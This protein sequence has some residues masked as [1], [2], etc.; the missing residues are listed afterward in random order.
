MF[1]LFICG[2]SRFCRPNRPELF[3]VFATLMPQPSIGPSSLRRCQ[4]AFRQWRSQALPKQLAVVAAPGRLRALSFLHDAT[5]KSSG[6]FLYRSNPCNL[7]TYIFGCP[8]IFENPSSQLDQLPKNAGVYRFMDSGGALLYIGKAKDLSKRIRAYFEGREHGPHIKKMAQQI[9]RLETISTASELEA[10]LLEQ[11]LIHQHKPKYNIIFRDDKT[12]GYVAITR[13]KHPQI[14]PYRGKRS[15][16]LELF[17]PHV[18]SREI[19]AR[20]EMA[21]KVFK[22]R[23]CDDS[24]YANRSRPC[25][26]HQ[27]GRCSAPC[28]PGHIADADYVAQVELARGYLSGK[29]ASLLSNMA[30]QMEEA[31]AKMEF[32]RAAQLRDQ[33]R[34]L[35]SSSTE[36]GMEGSG[37]AS[38][39]AIGIATGSKGAAAH[40]YEIRDGVISDIHAYSLE[41]GLR[42]DEALSIL[43]GQHY[44]D[45]KP[46]K[47]IVSSE[48]G[49]WAVE[50]LDFLSSRWGEAPSLAK[51]S[52]S[53]EHSWLAQA[54]RNARQSIAGS[55]GI[56][57][58]HEAQEAKLLALFPKLPGASASRIECFDISHFQGESAVASCVVYDGH[59]MRPEQYRLF[60]IAPENAGDDF[61]SMK[62]ALIRRYQN[63][64]V[65]DL[66]RLI[67]IDGG[68][69][70]LSKAQE[71]LALA[72]LEIPMIGIAKGVTRKLGNEEL[73]CSWGEDSKRLDKSDPALLLLS[74]IRDESHRFAISRNRK[75]IAKKRVDSP[76]M[77]IPNIGPAKRKSLLLA[78]GS[79]ANVRQASLE[80]LAKT[81]GIGPA[82]AEKIKRHFDLD[83]PPSKPS[84]RHDHATIA[85]TSTPT[86]KDHN[87]SK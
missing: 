28:V 40:V 7:R 15:K 16:A 24:T 72:G 51:P 86:P 64:L 37:S 61:A 73:I 74:H 2:A 46:P 1:F 25:V 66:P 47:R 76:L 44:L 84:A 32:E 43:L 18:D 55:E 38:F 48:Q 22:I 63:A 87:E 70:Q 75:S 30:K 4:P 59:K 62:E 26:L 65:E 33:L 6:L 3:L 69:G 36:Q 27:I 17:G 60:N 45:R 42:S 68:A 13:H 11:R 67:L 29:D 57:A 12:Y 41:G 39:D 9:F 78:F 58:R 79:A 20:I 56:E 50:D 83:S 31:S 82:L 14:K 71:A 54:E 8:M 35:S 49:S 23:A 10:L 5:K 34:L 19:R 77:Q 85:S 81:P 53:A 80:Q 52:S 21:Q